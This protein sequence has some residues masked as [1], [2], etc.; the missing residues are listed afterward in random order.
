MEDGAVEVPCGEESILQSLSL[1]KAG[2]HGRQGILNEA[3]EW[4]IARGQLPDADWEPTPTNTKALFDGD[5]AD[6]EA[7][8][9]AVKVTTQEER[10][11]PAGVLRDAGGQVTGL[12]GMAH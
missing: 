9:K 6:A 5:Y 3:A 10:K 2:G 1:L 8:H 4:R 12:R 11:S 7:K